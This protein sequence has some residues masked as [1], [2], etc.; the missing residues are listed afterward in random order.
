MI[1]SLTARSQVD[2]GFPAAESARFLIAL[3]M[4]NLPTPRLFFSAVCLT[5]LG[6]FAVP[7]FGKDL[8][9]TKR[10]LFIGPHENAAVADFNQD[11]HVDIVSGPNVFFG[12]Q[13]V[14]QPY[15]ANHLAA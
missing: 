1:I 10:H 15:R 4:K 14:P 5:A 6:G 7:A 3:L 13:F 11:G 9:W 12:P 2:K 8:A